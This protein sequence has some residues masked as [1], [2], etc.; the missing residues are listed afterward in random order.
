MIQLQPAARHTYLILALFASHC[1]GMTLLLCILNL[2]DDIMIG[3]A[4]N[5]QLSEGA[6]A[7]LVK[8]QLREEPKHLV[9]SQR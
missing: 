6:T 2:K 9:Q 7:F 3:S 4:F 8:I 5:L 1:N